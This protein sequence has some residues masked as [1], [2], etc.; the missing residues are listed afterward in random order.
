MHRAVTAFF[1]LILLLSPLSAME[2]AD[3]RKIIVGKNFRTVIRE[4]I[5]NPASVPQDSIFH[6]CLNWIFKNSADSDVIDF[7][8]DIFFYY[9]IMR[10]YDIVIP[11][12]KNR[13]IKNVSKM[14]FYTAFCKYGGWRIHTL[15]YK[16]NGAETDPENKFIQF[17]EI[18]NISLLMQFSEPYKI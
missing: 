6:S 15:S 16:I 18:G 13:S 14:E 12:L 2:T 9:Y 10:D 7:K 11:E 3:A 1:F 8:I 17:R 4:A 5:E